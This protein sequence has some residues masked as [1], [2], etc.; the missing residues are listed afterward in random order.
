MTRSFRKS[1]QNMRMFNLVTFSVH[2]GTS[3]YYTDDEIVD[4]IEEHITDEQWKVIGK[5]M[6]LITRVL[7]GLVVLMEVTL[8]LKLNNSG[9]FLPHLQ[10]SH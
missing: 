1:I 3:R 7:S 6:V 2:I 9:E 8:S 4:G 10:S 5:I